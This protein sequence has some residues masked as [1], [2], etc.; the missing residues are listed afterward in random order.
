MNHKPGSVK[1]QAVLLPSVWK[2]PFDSFHSNLPAVNQGAPGGN[3]HLA[4]HQ[5]K[6]PGF[7]A[8]LFDFAPGE[9]YSFG[10]AETVWEF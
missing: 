9:V 6:K 2:L 8:L 5:A 1:P 7:L 4:N 10:V 3:L